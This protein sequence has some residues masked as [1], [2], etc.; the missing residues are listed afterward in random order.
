MAPGEYDY[1]VEGGDC[2]PLNVILRDG[3][4]AQMVLTG[5]SSTFV[6]TWRGGSLTLYSGDRLEMWEAADSPIGDSPEG[7]SGQITGELTGAETNALPHGRVTKYEWSVTEPGGC[8][9][10]FLKGYI[11]RT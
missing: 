7:D 2:L 5:Y 1:T 11:I 8:K 9:R 10:T 3:T 6:A 4:G